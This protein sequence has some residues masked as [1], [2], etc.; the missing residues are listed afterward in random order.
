MPKHLAKILHSPYFFQKLAV[1]FINMF[2]VV[3]I[4]FKR[5]SFRNLTRILILNK[6]SLFY[7]PSV[8]RYSI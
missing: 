2:I 8:F 7:I 4:I 6:I 3:Y 5:L 1:T